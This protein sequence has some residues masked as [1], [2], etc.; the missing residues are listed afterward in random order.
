LKWG[1]IVGHI[2]HWV[3]SS[4]IPTLWGDSLSLA[5]R[6]I[7]MLTE[8]ITKTGNSEKREMRNWNVWNLWLMLRLTQMLEFWPHLSFGNQ[9]STSSVTMWS[10]G[11]EVN[12]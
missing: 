6:D 4:A 10:N 3:A 8:R 9:F 1:W 2:C 5:F 11:D 7:S 12:F